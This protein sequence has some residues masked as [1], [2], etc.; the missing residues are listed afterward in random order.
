[1]EGWR[2]RH[3]TPLIVDDVAEVFV[4]MTAL[5]Q[6]AILSDPLTRVVVG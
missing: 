5:S 2:P 1:V 6:V 3:E 4:V